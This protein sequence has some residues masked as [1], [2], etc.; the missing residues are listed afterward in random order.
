M[1]FTRS[2]PKTLLYRRSRL[3]IGGKMAA[4]SSLRC[5]FFLSAAHLGCLSCATLTTTSWC[6]PSASVSQVTSFFSQQVC[7]VLW[8]RRRQEPRSRDP[9]S[10]RRHPG[11]CHAGKFWTS[12]IPSQKAVALCPIY[13]LR[14]SFCQLGCV[15]S[16]SYIKTYFV[17]GLLKQLS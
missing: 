13:V 1:S 10:P 8:P 15:T 12:V 16:A 11:R 17:P 4:L 6:T 7:S 14:F 9:T 2:S 3:R 5:N